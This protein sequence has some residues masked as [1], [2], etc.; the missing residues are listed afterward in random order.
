MRVTFSIGKNPGEE[1]MTSCGMLIINAPWQ[2]DEKLNKIFPPIIDV[3]K[4]G[5]GPGLLVASL[6]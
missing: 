2:L 5:E 6:E 1:K 3:L 4:K